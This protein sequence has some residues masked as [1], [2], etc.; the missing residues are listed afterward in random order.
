[1]TFLIPLL[2]L[3]LF[4]FCFFKKTNVYDS[5]VQGA[6]QAIPLAT[7]LFPYLAC[8]LIAV[9]LLKTSGAYAI[10]QQIFSPLLSLLGI[11]AQLSQLILLKPLS[12]SGS[13]AILND[14]LAVYGTDSYIG[15]CACVMYG[16]SETVFYIATIYFS[17]TSI[18][19]LGLAMIV[20]LFCTLFSCILS[21]LLCRFI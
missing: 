19:K 6:K 15:R 7:S 4:V 3:F 8:M 20:A 2:I 14:L 13:L 12:G 5:F 18:K 1:M 17:K 9:E 16:S 10:L 21:C 11:P